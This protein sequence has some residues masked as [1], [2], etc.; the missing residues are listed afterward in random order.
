MNDAE[1]IAYAKM[2]LAIRN[3]ITREHPDASQRF[4]ELTEDLEPYIDTTSKITRI[5]VLY[6][7]MVTVKLCLR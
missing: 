5:Y 1:V 3:M 6:E 7:P 4:A 2:A